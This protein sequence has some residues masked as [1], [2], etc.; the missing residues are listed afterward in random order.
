MLLNLSPSC[1]ECQVAAIFL[2]G[3]DFAVTFLG[4]V[5]LLPFSIQNLQ[6]AFSAKLVA[7]GG[8][9]LKGDDP[10]KRFKGKGDGQ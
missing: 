2:S 8:E 10:S 3:I 1:R 5:H 4:L 6:K 7:T 9:E